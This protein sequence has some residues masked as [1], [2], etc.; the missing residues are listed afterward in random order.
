MSCV[1]SVAEQS[2]ISTNTVFPTTRLSVCLSVCLSRT[3]ITL[4]RLNCLVHFLSPCQ[5]KLSLRYR[6]SSSTPSS[7]L[8]GVPQGSVLGPIFFLLYTAYLLRLIDE[9]ELHSHLYAD[10]A[11]IY[12]SC[13]P[14]A[15]SAFQQRI[16]TCVVRMLPWMQANRLQLNAA[17]TE[18]LWCAPP[19]QQEYLPNIPLLIGSDTIQPVRCVRDLGI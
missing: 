6:G 18:Q 13:A 5:R 9:M 10:D 2:A 11:Q 1:T 7:L 19:W 16:S 14:D 17:K 12:G 8:C 15:A 3:G 4:Q